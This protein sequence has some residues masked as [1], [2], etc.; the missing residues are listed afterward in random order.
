MLP[1]N[2]ALVIR[3]QS[4]TLPH[5]SDYWLADN[6]VRQA[7][8]Q[9]QLRHILNISLLWNVQFQHCL[10]L[11]FLLLILYPCFTISTSPE[12]LGAGCLSTRQHG[13]ASQRQDHET[14]QEKFC[15]S[16]HNGSTDS[17]TWRNMDNDNLHISDLQCTFLLAWHTK[18]EDIQR[19]LTLV[20][21]PHSLQ[22]LRGV[23]QVRA[24][25]FPCSPWTGLQALTA[26][27]QCCTCLPR[28]IKMGY[29]RFQ[30]FTLT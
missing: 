24:V 29:Y 9:L 20:T 13:I 17:S 10:Q 27:F 3:S 25:S 22:G 4:P 26:R 5:W 30:T 1:T 16:N 19:Q 11:Q 23:L 6:S 8:T 21:V 15:S 28:Q 18:R 14:S 12:M 7:D 2:E